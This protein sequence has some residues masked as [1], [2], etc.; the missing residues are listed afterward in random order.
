[1][2]RNFFKTLHCLERLS[3][4]VQIAAHPF[5]LYFEV[6]PFQEHIQNIKLNISY[7]LKLGTFSQKW[8]NMKAIKKFINKSIFLQLAIY[9]IA[10]FVISLF[11]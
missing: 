11:L 2:T 1:M 10:N 6:A 5:T 4:E 3:Y 9:F 8:Q 7:I